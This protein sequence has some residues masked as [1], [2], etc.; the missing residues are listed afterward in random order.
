MNI[1]TVFVINTFKSNSYE[2][3]LTSGEG[4]DGGGKTAR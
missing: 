2:L 1:F 4:G 3:T